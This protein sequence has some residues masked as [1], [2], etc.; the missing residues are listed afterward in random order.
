MHGRVFF[1]YQ[2]F[3]KINQHMKKRTMIWDVLPLAVAALLA[4]GCSKEVGVHGL[5]IVEEGMSAG[6]GDKV[7]VDT[8]ARLSNSWVAGERVGI[9]YGYGDSDVEIRSGENAYY[10]SYDP[11]EDFVAWYPYYYGKNGGDVYSA[12]IQFDYNLIYDDLA[13]PNIPFPMVAFGARGDEA[14]M[15]RHVTG[16]L[17]FTVMN[18]TGETK[19]IASVNVNDPNGETIWP[20]SGKVLHCDNELNLSYSGTAQSQHFFYFKCGEND[21]ITLA[22]GE[23]FRCIL[24]VPVTSAPTNFEISFWDESD[25]YIIGRSM[26]G[27]SIERNH[28]YNL[29]QYNLQ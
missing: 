17:T 8:A 21:Y 29:G 25:T 23:S 7:I 3:I 15:F 1:Y 13:L 26:S 18:N 11:Y 6:H 27:L 2:L 14:L 28:M 4:T 24:P 20:S 5:R 12:D 22:P 16:A 9:Y 10:I 19:N